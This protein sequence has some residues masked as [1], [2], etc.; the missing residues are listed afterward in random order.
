MAHKIAFTN[1]NSECVC[2]NEMFMTLLED[3]L[4]MSTRRFTVF[5]KFVAQ[6]MYFPICILRMEVE[7]AQFVE[8]G[9]P[10]IDSW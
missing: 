8:A 1:P 7:I 2:V 3:R 10:G 4:C 9:R 6:K 5:R